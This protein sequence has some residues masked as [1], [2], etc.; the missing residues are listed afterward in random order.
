MYSESLTHNFSLFFFY[1]RF[2]FFLRSLI[3]FT[4]VNVQDMLHNEDIKL[5]WDFKLSL[6][7]DLVRVSSADSP[8]V[9]T[10]DV[11]L[12][13]FVLMREDQRDGLCVASLGQRSFF[14]F[15]GGEGGRLC[16]LSG[17]RFLM[18]SC[19]P[20]LSYPAEH[21]WCVCVCVGV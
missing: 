19:H 10:S 16:R 5:D 9:G 6:L 14:F 13:F 11:V 8:R 12:L 15:G 21:L 17:T 3:D 2:L 18:K 1:S 7:T 4:I 20:T